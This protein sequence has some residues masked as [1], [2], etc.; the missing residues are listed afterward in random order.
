MPKSIVN[1]F[2]G[3]AKDEGTANALNELST[4]VDTLDRLAE[5]GNSQELTAV[6]T[7]HTALNKAVEEVMKLP[8]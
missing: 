5:I 2:V 8:K 1:Q 6:I 7:L 4:L 3:Y